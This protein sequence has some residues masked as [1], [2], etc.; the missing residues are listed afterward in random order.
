MN[1]EI[2][3]AVLRTIALVETSC[4]ALEKLNMTE[5]DNVC[6]VLKETR[7]YTDKLYTKFVEGKNE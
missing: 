4:S 5:T 1:D 7:K 6:I 2:A 3:E